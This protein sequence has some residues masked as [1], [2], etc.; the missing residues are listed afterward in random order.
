MSSLS[1]NRFGLVRHAPTTWNEEK[2]IQGHQDISL[3]TNGIRLA[4]EWGKQLDGYSWD[5]ILCSDL[6]RTRKTA[7]LV[8]R[9]LDLPI[10][11]EPRLREQD[12]GKWSGTTVAALKKL[13]P[14]L[15]RAQE[16]QGWNFRPPGGESRREVQARS[17]AA[18]IDAAA[19]W[20]GARILVFC[21]GGVIKCL[22]YHLLQR[23]FLPEEPQVLQD[24][25]LH[26]LA[27]RN[28]ILTIDQLNALQL[29]K[30]TGETKP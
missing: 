22:L 14:G 4:E 23:A 11:F 20:P 12:W 17:R 16:R 21:H 24:Y 27:F 13:H 6:A 9:I 3:S 30:C 5:R 15:V 10:D 2:R 18:L 1:A 7:E 28:G 8:N 19:T 25:S 29:D 26:L